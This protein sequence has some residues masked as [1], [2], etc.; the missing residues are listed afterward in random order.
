[1]TQSTNDPGPAVLEAVAET[2]CRVYRITDGT[3][4]D[5]A[6]WY[7]VQRTPVRSSP[8]QHPPAQE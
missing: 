1:M 7:A 4:E 3:D 2:Y 8:R 5:W 6:S